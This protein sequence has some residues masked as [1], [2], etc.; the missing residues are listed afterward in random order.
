MTGESQAQIQKFIYRLSTEDYASADKELKT[1][2]TDKV[3]KRFDAML[4][5]VR[6]NFANKK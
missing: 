2:V 5:K 3:N 6:K 1:I 4:E